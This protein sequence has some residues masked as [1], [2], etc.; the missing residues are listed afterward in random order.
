MYTIWGSG[1]NLT[2]LWLLWVSACALISH[3]ACLSLSA[4]LGLS[5]VCSSLAVLWGVSEKWGS[6][7]VS[8][9]L[10]KVD[11]EHLKVS[12]AWSYSC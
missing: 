5:G 10:S 9:S 8:Y 3:S 1:E 4:I 2:S 7:V 11:W 6:L 12:G